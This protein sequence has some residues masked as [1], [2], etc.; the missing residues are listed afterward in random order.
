MSSLVHIMAPRASL[1]T[2][3]GEEKLEGLECLSAESLL[4]MA[5][6][7]SLPDEALRHYICVHSTCA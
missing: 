1:Q 7:C 5:E 4:V 6:L 3:V 2:F